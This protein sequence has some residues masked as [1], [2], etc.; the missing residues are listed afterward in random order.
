MSFLKRLF[1]GGAPSAPPP[2]P[3][4]SAPSDEVGAARDALRRISRA[5]KPLDWANAQQ[6][7]AYALFN[8]SRMQDPALA[9]QSLAEAIGALGAAI[10]ETPR[11]KAQLF[12]G[13]LQKFRG[14]CLYERARYLTDDEKGRV[15]ADAANA[16]G[17]ALETLTPDGTPEMWTDTQFFRGA[18]LNDLGIMRTDSQGERWLNEAIDCFDAVD[19]HHRA[20]SGGPHSIA[21]YNA[22]VVLEILGQ[23]T[24]G[25]AARA[26]LQR[27]QAALNDAAADANFRKSMGDI[28]TRLV[29]LDRAIAAAG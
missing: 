19:G 11:D 9:A 5:D 27:A 23:R 7:L 18:A 10:E 16:F 17:R 3:I 25:A 8:L 2:P 15:L 28:D 6:V 14:Q 20:T 24:Q 22:F 1:G 21:R 4:V 29:Q 12:W 26:Y 13:S